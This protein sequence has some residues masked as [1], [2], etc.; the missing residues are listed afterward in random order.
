MNRIFTGYIDENDCIGDSLGNQTIGGG[1]K[2]TI[3]GN[4]LSIDDAI[5]SLSGTAQGDFSVASNLTV[6]TD[7]TINN[8]L[9][10]GNQIS[11]KNDLIVDGTIQV[12]EEIYV[13]GPIA[14]GGASTD[15]ILVG[16]I[17][18]RVHTWIS[19]DTF[20]VTRAG[21]IEFL[22]V[23]G[24]GSGGNHNAANSANGGGGGGGV[25]YKSAHYVTPGVYPVVV[26]AGG[27]PIAYQTQSVG[28]SGENST[29][30]GFIA[31]G[32]GG[33]ASTGKT[34]GNNRSQ[35]GG[36]S[37]GSSNVY[38]TASPPL[39]VD[40]NGA[41]GYGNSGASG[42]LNYTGGGGGGAGSPAPF[43]TISNT[44]GFPGG[45]GGRGIPFNITGVQVYY[46]GG[47]G[48]GAYTA[49]S[50]YAG[51][52][53]HGGGRG[54]GRTLYSPNNELVEEINNQTGGYRTPDAI[55][56]TG[57]GGGAGSNNSGTTGVWANRGSG[58]GGSGIVIV[59]YRV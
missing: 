39:Q 18:Y 15:D 27:A 28:N 48:G 49:G 26:G 58:Q 20:T 42:A 6:G 53:W 34:T 23:A 2:G 10:V 57:G 7:A 5:Q 44:D 56:N 11:A 51:D 4:F 54:W 47:G 13:P 9:T 14:T 31:I 33:G 41:R 46:A 36:S 35:A 50:G 43:V 16:G 32:G 52:G 19:T 55:P 1:S 45:D 38:R 21:E 17:D 29:F 3:N 22:I 8:N 40:Y 12:Y 59:R 24:G 37:G 25:L 30:L